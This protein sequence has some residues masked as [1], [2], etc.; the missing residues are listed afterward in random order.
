LSVSLKTLRP[1]SASCIQKRA[2]FSISLKKASGFY[3]WQ[4]G[5][6]LQEQFPEDE[7]KAGAA[8]HFMALGAFMLH[9][10][11]LSK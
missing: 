5:P 11:T 10:L 1:E 9:T 8:L 2:A 7:M 4:I 3:G 6:R